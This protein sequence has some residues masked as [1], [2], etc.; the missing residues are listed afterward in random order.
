MSDFIEENSREIDFNIEEIPESL[1]YKLPEVEF[2]Y[3]PIRFGVGE[4]LEIEYYERLFEQ[5]NP[6]LLHQFPMLYYLVEE[7]YAEATKM[8]PLEHIEARKQEA[9][10]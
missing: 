8:T 4:Y 10:N 7:W 5:K 9:T 3:S 2:T 1:I 6:G